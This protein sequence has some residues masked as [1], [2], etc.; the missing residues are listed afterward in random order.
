M[1]SSVISFF[2]DF[3]FGKCTFLELSCSLVLLLKTAHLYW[4]LKLKLL[5]VS[6]ELRV[7]I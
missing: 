7:A 1:Q 2:C 4:V 3:I 5:I 6:K